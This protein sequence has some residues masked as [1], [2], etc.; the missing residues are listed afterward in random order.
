[1]I[2]HV[3]HIRLLLKTQKEDDWDQFVNTLDN[4]DNQI[5]RLNKKPAVYSLM[6]PNGLAFS[7]E[8]KANIFADSLEKQFSTNPGL[9]IPKVGDCILKLKSDPFQP[10]GIPSNQTIHHTEYRPTHHR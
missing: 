7:T 3:K 5:F 8:E 4:N 1:M 9:I 6:D 10:S 2:A